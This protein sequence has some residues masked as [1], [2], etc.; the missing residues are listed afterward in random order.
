MGRGVIKKE[1]S[2]ASAAELIELLLLMDEPARQAVYRLIRGFSEQDTDKSKSAARSADLSVTKP[3][4]E[5]R[6]NFQNTDQLINLGGDPYS[7]LRDA[8]A[9]A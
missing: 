4:F 3:S 6:L 1:N 8:Y 9:T 7:V 5:Q 2:A